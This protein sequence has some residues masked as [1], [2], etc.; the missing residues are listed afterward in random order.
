[1]KFVGFP[2]ANTAWNPPTCGGFHLDKNT[3]ELYFKD[4]ALG[5][6]IIAIQVAEYGKDAKGKSYLKGIVRRDMELVVISA[7]THVP[8]LS[9]ID[10]AANFDTT[11][12]AGHQACFNVYANDPDSTDTVSISCYTYLISKGASFSSSSGKMNSKATFCWTPTDSD[13]ATYPYQIVFGAVDNAC[14]LNGRGYRAYRIFVRPGDK[15]TITATPQRCGNVKFLAGAK[16][17]NQ[18]TNYLWSGD[19][20]LYSV[21]SSFTHHYKKGGIYKYKLKVSNVY[22]CGHTDSGFVIVPPYLSS[23]LPKDTTVCTNTLLPISIVNS[24]GIPTYKYLWIT[25]D[26]SASINPLIVKDTSFIVKVNDSFCVSND[27]MKVKTFSTPATP[28]IN[29]IGKDSLKASLAS[30]EYIWYSDSVKTPDSTQ[31]I[32]ASVSGKYTVQL[33]DSNGCISALSSAYNFTFTGVN[34]DISFRSIHVYPNPTTGILTIEIPGIKDAQLSV[35]NITGQVQ[36]QSLINEK[37]ELD[38]HTLSKGVYLLRMQSKDG[39]L[40]DRVVKQ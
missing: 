31:Q 40:M 30:S 11:I 22:G 4:T 6:T 17:N 23:M 2:K 15:D 39:V 38:L 19:D 37:A 29:I 21:S 33:V 7:T 1:M 20:G 18:I 27:T 28:S 16:P 13:V 12:C 26:T 10:S 36:F 9:G 32:Y 25:G 35:M 24:Y 14:P 5:N 3:G 34:N 8:L